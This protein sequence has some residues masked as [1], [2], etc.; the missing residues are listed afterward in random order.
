M[1]LVMRVRQLRPSIKASLESWNASAPT[2]VYSSVLSSD[3]TDFTVESYFNEALMK[4]DKK[5]NQNHI[6]HHGKI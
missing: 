6:S 1:H 3:H 5:L 2:G 4:I